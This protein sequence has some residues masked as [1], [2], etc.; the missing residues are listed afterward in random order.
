MNS[1]MSTSAVVEKRRARGL[2]ERYEMLR[3]TLAHYLLLQVGT[4]VAAF[5]FDAVGPAMNTLTDKK[6][7]L[8]VLEVNRNGGGGG[9]DEVAEKISPKAVCM[10]GESFVSGFLVQAGQYS[11]HVNICDVRLLG[12]I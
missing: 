9:S 5:G 1:A 8:K 4:F 10:I 2:E 11:C 6:A 7:E 3:K 12:A